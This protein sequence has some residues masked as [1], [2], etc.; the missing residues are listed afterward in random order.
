LVKLRMLMWDMSRYPTELS[1][2]LIDDRGRGRLVC[3]AAANGNAEIDAGGHVG[4]P[5]FCTTERKLVLGN[6]YASEE[7]FKLRLICS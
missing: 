7:R 2:G 4:P 1:L 3:R 6:A 5:L